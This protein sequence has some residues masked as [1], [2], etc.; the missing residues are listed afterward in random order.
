MSDQPIRPTP[1]ELAFGGTDFEPQ[2]F[3]RIE[4]EAREVG[5]LNDASRFMMARTVSAMLREFLAESPDASVPAFG[6]LLYHAYEFRLFGKKLL[7]IDEPTLRELLEDAGPVGPWA[8]VPPAPAG[9]V[10]L[11]RNLVWARIEEGAQAEPVDGI[12]WAMPGSNEPDERP[13]PRLDAL[14]VLGMVPGRPGFSTIRV[15]AETAAEPQGHWSDITARA[16]G[17]DFE[18]VLPGGEYQHL[19]A[20]VT[21]GEVLKLL[22]RVFHLAATRPDRIRLQT[23]DG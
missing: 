10:Q 14:V 2:G 15:F 13:F 3:E 1:Y 4:T 8:M 6:L 22:S 11:P 9:Y 17:R 18:N 23:N 19:Y 21:Q 5:G 7:R 20:L 16:D 12:F